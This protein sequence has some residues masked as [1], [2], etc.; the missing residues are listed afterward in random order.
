[1][2]AWITE[3]I[4]NR[5]RELLTKPR[6]SKANKKELQ[7]NDAKLGPIPKGESFEQAKTMAPIEK[8]IEILKKNQSS[9]P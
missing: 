1:M 8:S 4:L 9:N 5:R 6:L 2:I 7:E 3:R